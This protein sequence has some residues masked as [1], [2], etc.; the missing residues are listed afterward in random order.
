MKKFIAVIS[1][2]SALSGGFMWRSHK[3]P[4]LGGGIYI[5][6]SLFFTCDIQGK[7]KDSN[8]NVR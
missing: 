4:P 5:I 6:L 2:L 8:V 7:E 1:T 3:T